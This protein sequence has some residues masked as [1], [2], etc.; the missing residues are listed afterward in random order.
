MKRILMILLLVVAC[1]LVEPEFIDFYN[2]KC[3]YGS[4]KQMYLLELL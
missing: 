3:Y 4:V 1:Q 2:G